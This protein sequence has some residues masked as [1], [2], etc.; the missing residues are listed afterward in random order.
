M[1]LFCEFLHFCITL[2]AFSDFTVPQTAA[3]ER[4]EPQGQVRLL[5]NPAASLKKNTS[6]L[7]SQKTPLTIVLILTGNVLSGRGRAEPER[8]RR[9]QRAGHPQHYR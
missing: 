2:E 9:Q 6:D 5:T 4:E 7:I 8:R 3:V 1:L